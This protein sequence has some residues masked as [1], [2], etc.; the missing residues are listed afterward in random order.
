MNNNLQFNQLAIFSVPQRELTN[1]A[2][3]ALDKIPI[4]N[5]KNSDKVQF[6][7]FVFFCFENSVESQIA[8]DLVEDFEYC[9][10]RRIVM[11]VGGNPQRVLTNRISHG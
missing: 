7:F 3:R 11:T 2:E 10:Q 8:A 6:D 1:A 4:R 5:V 9:N